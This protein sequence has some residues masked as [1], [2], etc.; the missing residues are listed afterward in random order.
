MA[1]ERKKEE[2]ERRRRDFF[3]RMRDWTQEQIFKANSCLLAYCL[4]ID[5]KDVSKYIHYLKIWHSF[6]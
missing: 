1:A 2:E 6:L 3:D 5:N 4:T